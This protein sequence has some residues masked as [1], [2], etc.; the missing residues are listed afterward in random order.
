MLMPQSC[1]GIDIPAHPTKE[2]G[3]N[4]LR[5]IKS[6]NSLR[7][8]KPSATMAL[9]MAI[10]LG[11]YVVH[12]MGYNPLGFKNIRGLAKL[13]EQ[14]PEVLEDEL[15][16]M[17]IEM[18]WFFEQH[19]AVRLGQKIYKVAKEYDDKKAIS[20]AEDKKVPEDLDSRFSAL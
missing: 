5:T 1:V 18:H 17:A 7:N 10:Q 16:E 8:L 20:L 19:W 11:E 15:T 6:R 9:C 13:I 2:Q 12:D 14:H 3:E 4:I